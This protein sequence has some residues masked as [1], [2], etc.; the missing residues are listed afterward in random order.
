MYT[1][2]E[3]DI[4]NGVI[5]G[6]ESLHIPSHAHVLI[7][8]LKQEEKIS[9]PA[10]PHKSARGALRQYANAALAEKE[11]AAWATCVREKHEQD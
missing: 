8:V 7:T 1:T 3:A 9:P 5:R 10:M 4:D 11:K 2:I 6:S